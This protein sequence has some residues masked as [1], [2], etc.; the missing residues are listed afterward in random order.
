MFVRI[1][2]PSLIPRHGFNSETRQSK[3]AAL[4]RPRR[5]IQPSAMLTT[6]RGTAGHSKLLP[7]I[8]G[9]WSS[10]GERVSLLSSAREQ[11]DRWVQRYRA[12]ALPGG[13]SVPVTEGGEPPSQCGSDGF[14]V[15]QAPGK[16]PVRAPEAVPG[17]RVAPLPGA[18]RRTRHV[19]AG[20][21]PRFYLPQ[22]S[23]PGFGGACAACLPHHRPLTWRTCPFH[24]PV[25]LPTGGNTSPCLLTVPL[26]ADGTR[27]GWLK[28][29]VPMAR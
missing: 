29:V 26:P 16:A 7:C 20:P 15:S 11:R 22:E 25:I 2:L 19:P 21:A 4:T 18:P 23:L 24:P 9:H 8:V 5:A 13:P 28:G 17:H 3:P 1:F 12:H 27:R 10:D 6:S 14:S